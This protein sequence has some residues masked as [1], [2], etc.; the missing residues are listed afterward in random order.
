MTRGVYIRTKEHNEKIR[1]SA[2]ERQRVGGPGFFVKGHSTWNKNKPYQIGQGRYKRT[3]EQL[4]KLRTQ[5]IGKT[6][7][8]KGMTGSKSHCWQ[9]GK[10]S[11]TEAVRRSEAYIKWRAD[12]YKRDGWTCQTCGFRGHGKDIEAHH[13]IPMR[14]LVKQAHMIEG[15]YD[16]KYIFAMSIP[17]MFDI[18]NGITLCKSC[19]ILTYKGEG[20]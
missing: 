6:A 8:N 15:S 2:L 19:H 14:E 16:D 12:V 18:S 7:W 3:E 10:T 11:I 17:K 9:G 4:N 13:I 1:A 5:G 20:K